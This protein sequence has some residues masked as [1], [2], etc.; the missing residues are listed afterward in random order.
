MPPMPPNFATSTVLARRVGRIAFGATVLL[1]AVYLWA[2]AARHRFEL[3]GPHQDGPS[4]DGRRIIV[5]TWLAAIALWGAAR[6]VL[7]RLRLRLDPDRLVARSAVVP[8]LG[9]A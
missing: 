1:G 6:L 5:I 7:P 9:V 2:S 8:A 4:L 3:I